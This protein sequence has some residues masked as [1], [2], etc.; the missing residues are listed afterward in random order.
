VAVD[1]EVLSF[2]EEG[3]AGVLLAVESGHRI[4]VYL[5]GLSAAEYKSCNRV[6]HFGHG[7]CTCRILRGK[8]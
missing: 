4:R 3:L 1:G 7:C 6:L 2:C 5:S 8:P